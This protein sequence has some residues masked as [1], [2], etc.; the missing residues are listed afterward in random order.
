[1]VRV[2]RVRHKFFRSFHETFK[3]GLHQILKTHVNLPSV[4]YTVGTLDGDVLR[5]KFYE[6]ELQPT[7]MDTFKISKVYARTRRA[8]PITGEE[9][10]KVS[11]QGL[12]NRFDSFVPT[13]E[14]PARRI[15]NAAR[16]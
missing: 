4:M 13:A 6:S 5:H 12:P 8:N 10:V 1:M 9:E 14:V 15:R 3:T 2:V 7:R 11:F 16:S